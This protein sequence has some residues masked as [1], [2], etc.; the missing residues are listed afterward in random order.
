VTNKREPV[1]RAAAQLRR[2][3]IAQSRY[4]QKALLR[5]DLEGQIEL[6]RRQREGL[7]L[8]EAVGDYAITEH[9]RGIF[10]QE[11]EH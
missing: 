10:R 8:R 3:N 2:A 5:F 1:D 4:A 6:I 9:V 11:R 7:S